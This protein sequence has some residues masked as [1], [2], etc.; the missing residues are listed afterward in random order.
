[1]LEKG[2]LVCIGDVEDVLHAYGDTGNKDLR[3]NI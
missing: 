2:N 3:L 1:L